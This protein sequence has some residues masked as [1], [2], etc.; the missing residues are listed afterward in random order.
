MGHSIDRHSSLE[1][2]AR[3]FQ[4][5]WD[6]L[7]KIGER[8]VILGSEA[9]GCFSNSKAATPATVPC[10]LQSFSRLVSSVSSEVYSSLFLLAMLREPWCGWAWD[11]HT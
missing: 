11:P 4:S 7:P 10:S 1:Y 3:G 2:R 8:A 9:Q 5:A 6:T